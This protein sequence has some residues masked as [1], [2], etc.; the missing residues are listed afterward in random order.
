M[1]AAGPGPADPTVRL[2]PVRDLLGSRA[3]AVAALGRHPGRQLITRLAE[4]SPH[5]ATR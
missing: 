5:R 3:G 1:P 2:A 4:A